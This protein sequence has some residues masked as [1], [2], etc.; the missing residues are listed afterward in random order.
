M[1]YC[2]CDYRKMGDTSLPTNRSTCSIGAMSGPLTRSQ[3]KEDRRFSSA[4]CLNAV[5]ETLFLFGYDPSN[6]RNINNLQ[7]VSEKVKF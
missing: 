5:S 7:A 2:E 3:L 4:T 1:E 6:K